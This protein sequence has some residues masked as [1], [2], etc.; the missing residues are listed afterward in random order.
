[1]FRL[2]APRAAGLRAARVS[3]TPAA[4]TATV[5]SDSRLSF[6]AA[7]KQAELREQRATDFIQRSIS[8]KH[9]LPP[10]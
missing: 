3:K 5:E 9:L 7:Q 8:S 4:L 6:S 10:V 2:F 1:M